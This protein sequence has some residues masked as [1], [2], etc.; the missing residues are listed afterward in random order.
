[1]ITVGP[2]A[3]ARLAVDYANLPVFDRDALP[4]WDAMRE[5]TWRQLDAMMAVGLDVLVDDAD[6]Y[7]GAAEMFDDVRINRRIRVLGTHATGGHP[8]WS[9]DDNDAF[10]AVHDVRGHFRAG[11][12]FDR[13]GE[14]AAYRLHSLEYSPLARRALATET[15]GQNAALVASADGDTFDVQRIA[16]LPAW[17][18]HRDAMAPT[19]G[20][21]LATLEDAAARHL[22]GGLPG[23]IPANAG[24]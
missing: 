19:A 22:A 4:A 1:M 10:R 7:G 3:Q 13:H 6:P 5:E 11:R 14:E 8:Y 9:D 23:W 24:E 17:A 16:I 2:S 20:E 21:Y 18:L 15:R 12:G